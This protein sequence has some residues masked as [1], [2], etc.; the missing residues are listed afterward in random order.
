[1][2]IWIRTSTTRNAF[3]VFRGDLAQVTLLVWYEV[4][5]RQ[6]LSFKDRLNIVLILVIVDIP[7]DFFVDDLMYMG[8]DDFVCNSY[9]VYQPNEPKIP[10]DL[11][12]Y[13]ELCMCDGQYQQYW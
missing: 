9:V 5:G 11:M 1:M 4:T 12:A 3:K 7:M 6:E 10:A 8:S 13:Q 2:V